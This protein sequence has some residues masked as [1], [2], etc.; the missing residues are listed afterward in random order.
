[1]QPLDKQTGQHA[2]DN[3]YNSLAASPYQKKFDKVIG[4]VVPAISRSRLRHCRATIATNC[5]ISDRIRTA[6]INPAR[7][8]T[9]IRATAYLGEDPAAVKLSDVVG[10]AIAELVSGEFETGTRGVLEG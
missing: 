5:T 4:S 2:P 9:A 1:M 8:G 3:E 7:T 6:I 10:V